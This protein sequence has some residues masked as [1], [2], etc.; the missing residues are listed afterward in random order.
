[1]ATKTK[2]T[3]FFCNETDQLIDQL[4]TNQNYTSIQKSE[5]KVVPLIDWK[6][7]LALIALSLTIEWFIRKFNGLI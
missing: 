4:V 2:G 1:L 7:L 6:W 3:A 5:Q